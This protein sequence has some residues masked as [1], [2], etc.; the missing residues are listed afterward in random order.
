MTEAL[1]RCRGV[2]ALGRLFKFIILDRDGTSCDASLNSEIAVLLGFDTPVYKHNVALTD[3]NACD[4]LCMDTA[5]SVKIWEL[6]ELR[7][8]RSVGVAADNYFIVF[9]YP[10]LVL[11]LDLCTFIQIFCRAC[12]ILES[13]DVQISPK[14]FCQ[15][16]GHPPQ[17]VVHEVPLVT[18]QNENFLLRIRIFE[19]QRFAWSYPVKQFMRVLTEFVIIGEI[20]FLTKELDRR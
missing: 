6:V 10:V 4:A 13:N 8:F 17:L 5:P 1:F 15:E 3:F 14:A 7:K 19:Q 12:W 9:F 18:V 20:I 11:T 16:H 2:P